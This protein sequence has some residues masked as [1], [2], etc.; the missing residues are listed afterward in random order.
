MLY[1][2]YSSNLYIFIRIITVIIAMTEIDKYLS[3]I[4]TNL[5]KYILI[6]PIFLVSVEAGSLRF[7][8]SKFQIK[9][10]S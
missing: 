3:V 4:D 7:H 2:N 10:L 8:I 1:K 5:D 9:I 6:R